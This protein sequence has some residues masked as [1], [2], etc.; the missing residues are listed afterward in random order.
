VGAA[1]NAQ[2]LLDDAELLSAAGRRAR[3]YALAA[4]AVEEAGK[5][6]ALST[7]AAMQVSLRAQAPV[8]RMLEWHQLK[9][10]GGLLITAIP[11]GNVATE[12]AAMPL[13][14][15]AGILEDAQVLAQDVDRLKQRGLYAD[16]DRSGQ[17]RL[18]SEVTEADVDAQLGRARQVTETAAAS[19]SVCGPPFD[20]G[21]PLRPLKAGRAGRSQPAPPWRVRVQQIS[22]SCPRSRK[23]KSPR[24]QGNPGSP[25]AVSPEGG[26]DV[27]DRRQR[28]AGARCLG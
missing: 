25:G 23:S 4:L 6:A 14:P 18:P 20:P 19:A 28:R 7:L 24:F 5:A 10:V 1:V 11:L 9:L 8:G 3:G 21:N 17:V 2:G 22:S 15:V 26:W 13:R 27:R 16:I 12:L